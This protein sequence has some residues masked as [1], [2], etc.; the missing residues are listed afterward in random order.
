MRL[1]TDAEVTSVL[2]V[3]SVTDR[4]DRALGDLGRGR[5]AS[6]VRVRATADGAMASALA[7]AWPAGGV[8]GGKLYATETGVFTF[9]VAVFDLEGTL[10]GIM[11]GD[12]LT[13]IR[14]A[15]GTGVAMR[16]LL[17]ETPRI[18]TVIGTGRQCAGHL[19]LLAD[20]F[21]GLAEVRI[22]GRRPGPL[23]A[24]YRHGTS[25]GLR[26]VTSVDA[27]AAVEDSDVILT[28]T[29]ARAPLF[30]ADRVQPGALVCALGS[31]KADRS[32]VDPAIA[33]RADV[34][35]VDSFDG[36]RRECGDLIAAERAGHFAWEDVIELAS[37]IADPQLL[38]Q[39]TADG[40]TLFESQ[41]IAL[42]DV[43]A[44]AI[45]VERFDQS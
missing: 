7:A 11:E 45:V 9:V 16:R 2:D 34:I 32:E 28:M 35:V 39:R 33:A 24:A 42:Q 3:R 37:V 22:V 12:S 1:I 31:T 26:V 36:A 15:A 43:V 27:A 44:G 20:E 5:A 21:P 38:A 10:L 6:T 18:A 8:T 17:R 4:L 40:I 25:L 19:E 13:R 30:P 41:G 14:T 23:E 29:S